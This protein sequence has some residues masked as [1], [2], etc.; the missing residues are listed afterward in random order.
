MSMNPLKAPGPDGLQAVFYQ[1]AWTLVGQKISHYVRHIME[2]EEKMGAIAEA[3]V[4]QIPKVRRPTLITQ[5]RPINLCNVTHKLV[6]EVLVNK[7]KPLLRDIV[8][9][10]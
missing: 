2:G 8:S 7:S 3:L 1:K 5:F 10:N 9:L 4:V 6:T